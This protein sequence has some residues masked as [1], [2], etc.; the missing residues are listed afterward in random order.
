MD[1]AEFKR[2]IRGWLSGHPWLLQAV[3]RVLGKP[4][5]EIAIFRSVVRPGDTVFDLGANTGQ[6]TCL[7]ST[8]VGVRGAVHSFEPIPPTFAM[9]QKNVARHSGK[10]PVFL[11][12]AAV[13]DSEGR[14]KMFVADGRFTE[15][16]MVRH[17]SEA[18]VA[19]FECPVI[20]LDSY[21]KK[22]NIGKVDVVKCDVEGAELLAMKGAKSIL[23]GKNPPILFLEAWSGWTKDFGYRPADLFGF[24]ERE[25]GYIVY[26]VYRGGIKRISAEEKLPS[27]SFPDF[28]NFLCVVPAVHGKRIESLKCAGIDII[29]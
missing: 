13:G 12:N 24:L 20:T 21:A 28:L 2:N 5:L 26:H 6:Y 1:F 9:L 23:K 7:F 29:I 10:C 19:M 11:N 22:N 25:A 14:I 17:N 15:A 8:L 3:F 27:D 16:S 18:P 4:Y